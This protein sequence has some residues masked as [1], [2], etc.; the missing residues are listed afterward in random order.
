MRLSELLQQKIVLCGEGYLFAL[1]KRGC[2]TIGP[3]VPTCVIDFPESVRSLHQELVNCGSDVVEAFTYYAHRTK[4]NVIQQGD[5]TYEVNN[6]ALILA[7]DVARKNGKLLAGNICN[8]TIWDGTPE[9]T[10]K[11]EADMREQVEIASKYDVDFIIA[12]TF[13]SLEE[14][15]L[16]LRIIQEF[17]LESVITLAPLSTG[18]TIE[19][20]SVEDAC[21]EL[22]RMGATCV[23]L[24]CWMGPTMMLP[25]LERIVNT[26]K[27]HNMDTPVAGLPVGYMTTCEKPTMQQMTN[28]EN[29]YMDL[30]KHTCTR[31]EA[32]DFAQKAKEI[33]VRYIGTCCGFLPHHLRAMSEVLGYKTISSQH[34][35]NVDLHFSNISNDIQRYACFD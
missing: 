24:N 25:L 11:V 10:L 31:F 23:G 7:K 4:M 6:R 22:A 1:E 28:K 21:L 30:E 13:N 9:N 26:L 20:I 19:D 17:N 15:K 35:S 32:A 33:G 27:T 5:L 2:I 16:A 12:E 14:A 29:I 18:K 8:S 34:S 3:Y